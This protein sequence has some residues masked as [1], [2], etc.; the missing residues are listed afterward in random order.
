MLS[1]LQAYE[2]KAC[3]LLGRAI[4]A[5]SRVN[6]RRRE[7]SLIANHRQPTYPARITAQKETGNFHN[8]KFTFHNGIPNNDEN[9]SHHKLTKLNNQ[10][11]FT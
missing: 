10:N 11:I 2:I 3:I 7:P 4:S 8:P 9:K 6:E 1:D 5:I